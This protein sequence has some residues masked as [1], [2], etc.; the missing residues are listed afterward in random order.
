MPCWLPKPMR[1]AARSQRSPERRDT[2]AG[3][4][5]RKRET[6]AGE[7]TRQVPKRRTL[8]FESAIIERY[9]RREAPVEE[10]L[11]EMYLAGVSG[12][13]MEDVTEALWGTRG[14]AGTVSTFNQ[15]IDKHSEAWRNQSL[16]GNPRMSSSMALS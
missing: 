10:A 4:Y 12:R 2:R 6:K 9:R 15:K 7:V 13:R 5:P 11:I 1:S 14:S 8:P 3:R 16:R